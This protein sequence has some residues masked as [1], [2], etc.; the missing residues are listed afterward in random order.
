MG[1]EIIIIGAGISGLSAG[2][3][4]QMNGYKTEIYEMNKIPGGLCT[5]WQRKGY[6]FDISM[7]MLTGSVSGP[8][9]KMWEELGVAGNF[10]FHVHNQISKIEGMGKE[11]ILSTNRK[12]L[13]KNMLAISPGDSKLIKEFNWDYLRPRY[14]ESCVT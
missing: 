2:C 5:A 1:K 14:D 8:I 12:E 7:H 13:E 4:A 3:Y 10:K 9:H 6:T 11:L